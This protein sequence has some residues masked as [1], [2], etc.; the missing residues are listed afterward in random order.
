MNPAFQ[1]QLATWGPDAPV[2]ESVSLAEAERYCRDLAKSHYENFPVATWLLP[3]R[4]HQHFYNVY[5]FCRWADDLGDEVGDPQQSLELLGWWRGELSRIAEC[6]PAVAGGSVA[7]DG[8]SASSNGRPRGMHPVFVALRTTIREFDVPLEP[9]HDLV[10]AFEQDQR[11]AEY[12]TFDQLHDYCRRS[13]NPVGRIVL[14]LCGAF[15]ADNAELSD[16]ICTGLQLTNFWQDVARDFDMG[17]VYLPAE[18]CDRF[19]YSRE[20]L[21]H[22]ETNAAFV[23]LMRFQVD[24]ARRFLHDGLPLAERMRGRLRIDIEL[25]ARG[26]LLVLDRIEGIGYGVWH[27][28]PV[29]RKR[30]FL[31][32]V[33]KALIRSLWRIRRAKP[34]SETVRRP[35]G[36]PGTAP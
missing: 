30:H 7:A 19:G 14:H 1:Q 35:T 33:F 20:Q 36:E 24:R 12:D 10:S 5:A 22:R 31:G 8:L 29:L 16:A 28:R 32:P 25:F 17:R 21:Y 3:R 18:D 27:T 9:F 34:N 2:A 23:E 15:T 26:G 13:A 11:V 4:L 6:D